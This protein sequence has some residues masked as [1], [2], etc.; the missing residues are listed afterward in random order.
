M[1]T[2][3][4]HMW[5]V[6]PYQIVHGLFWLPPHGKHRRSQNTPPPSV[7]PNPQ[8]S[9][10]TTP[11][12]SLPPFFSA[13]ARVQPASSEFL[14]TLE[15]FLRSRGEYELLAQLEPPTAVYAADV[16]DKVRDDRAAASRKAW[17]DFHVAFVCASTPLPSGI[18]Q[19]HP[20]PPAFTLWVVGGIA[21]LLHVSRKSG[22]TGR[23]SVLSFT[24]CRSVQGNVRWGSDRCEGPRFL[25][26]R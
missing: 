17:A 9:M 25:S 24:E 14:P 5:K 4:Y 19:A 10:S 2:A 18:P 11:L 21:S 3:L 23:I 16:L 1:F 13:L 6:I 12:M 22:V 8:Q 7:Q 15:R 20:P 26:V